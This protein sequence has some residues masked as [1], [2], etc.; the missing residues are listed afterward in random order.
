MSNSFMKLKD[1]TAI[2]LITLSSMG[3]R[4][5]PLDRRSVHTGNLYEMR[6]TSAESN[7]LNVAASL[8][9]NTK[10]LTKFVA[11]S[12]IS[13]LIKGEL[14][15]RN[16]AFEG[17]SVPQGGPWGYRHQF[18]IA[19]AGF[20]ARG[21]RVYNDRAGEV[22]LT[23][24]ADEFDLTRIFETDGARILH[25]SGLVAAMSESTG[26]ACLDIASKAKESGTVISFDMNYRASFWTGRE[27]E[28]REIFS[29][30]ASLADILLGN[31]EDFQLA[32]GIR[33]PEAG[34]TNLSDKIDGFKGMI[35]R[36]SESYPN[37][38]IFAT[39]LR[40]VISANRHAWGALLCVDGTWFAE[41]LREIEIYD[42]IGGGDGFAAGLL[43]G[44]LKGYEPESWLQLGW[45]S[46][47]LAAGSAEDYASPADEEQLWG[48]YSGNARVKR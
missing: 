4:L 7:V 29:E 31:E 45:A 23:L 1:E 24:S 42:R 41:P 12:P 6:S 35:G 18:N 8:G 14:R 22:G 9:L 16:I 34:G 28:L 13:A 3:I 38:R 10:V 43:Y 26:K 17:V 32:L 37:A 15:K 21:P 48:I 39:T 20:G 44:V 47:A 30:I 5:T 40:E 25:L 27:T 2:D 36:V 11:D 46:G 33:G 19:D